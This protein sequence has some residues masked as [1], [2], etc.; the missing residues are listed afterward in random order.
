MLRTFLRCASPCPAG[1]KV[2]GRQRVAYTALTAAC[3][4]NAGDPIGWGTMAPLLAAVGMVTLGVC[5]I[6]YV[7]HVDRPVPFHDDTF[8]DSEWQ[9][10]A[11]RPL[12]GR[13][14]TVVCDT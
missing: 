14:V 13:F 8:D 10:P 9:H 6:C 2:S 1:R 7:H 4:L 5:C 11:P 3:S 12:P